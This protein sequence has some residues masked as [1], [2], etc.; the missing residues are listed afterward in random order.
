MPCEIIQGLYKK[1]LD[2][3]PETVRSSALSEHTLTEHPT[4]I[5]TIQN[6]VIAID[7]YKSAMEMRTAEVRTINTVRPELNRKLEKARF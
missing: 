1:A 6:F 5:T 7:P 4:Y 2:L 3:F